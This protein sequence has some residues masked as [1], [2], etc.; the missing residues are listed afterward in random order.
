MSGGVDSTV[1]AI[2]LKCKG[3]EVVRVF[4]K[5]W[6]TIDE[7][8]HC[9]ADKEAEEAEDI[10]KQLDIPIHMV[11]FLLPFLCT[12]TYHKGITSRSLMKY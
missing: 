10:C 2:L 9:Q 7:F 1:S 6:D 12:G 8:G 5:N 11:S 4:M 3:Y